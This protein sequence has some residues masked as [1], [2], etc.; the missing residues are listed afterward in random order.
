MVYT[1]KYKENC[2]CLCLFS[3]ALHAGEEKEG[4]NP[5]PGEQ[6]EEGNHGK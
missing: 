3:S 2:I 5:H 4:G 1:Q 6:G